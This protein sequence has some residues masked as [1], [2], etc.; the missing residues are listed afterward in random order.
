MPNKNALNARRGRT[1]SL[2]TAAAIL[3]VLLSSG[4]TTAAI[5]SSP[6]PNTATHAQAAKPLK[7]I[8]HGENPSLFTNRMGIGDPLMVWPFWLEAEGV[9]SSYQWYRDGKKIP[10][11]TGHQHI[12]VAADKGKKLHAVV[13]GTKTGYA[14]TRVVSEA[15]TF[16]FKLTFP[17][18]PTIVP[19][20]VP[21]AGLVL[22]ASTSYATDGRPWYI[23]PDDFSFQWKRNGKPIAGATTDRYLVTLEDVGTKISVTVRPLA[24][25][26]TT[27]ASTSKSTS[28]V[29]NRSVVN[30]STPKVSGSAKAGS[31]LR[32][33]TGKWNENAKTF[34]FQWYANGDPIQGATKPSYKIAAGLVGQKITV[35]VTATGDYASSTA[36]SAKTS[37]VRPR[38]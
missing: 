4:P 20:G 7:A 10:G 31:T 38:I 11:D 34:A 2:A 29:V 6:T 36:I 18:R 8:P 21:F 35:K 15:G 1:I 32:A 17:G 28:T 23:R 13:T 27:N 19:N 25:G 30:I 37:T 16:D 12:F 9:S 33:T 5:A 14:P 26:L 22:H 24:K 3:T